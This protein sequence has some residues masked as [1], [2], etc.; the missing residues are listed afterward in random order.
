M[1]VRVGLAGHF[2]RGPE[3]TLMGAFCELATTGSRRWIRLRQSNDCAKGASQSQS[4]GGATEFGWLAALVALRAVSRWIAR[5]TDG[6][7]V[8][9]SGPLLPIW[10][11]IE[12][13]MPARWAVSGTIRRHLEVTGERVRSGCALLRGAFSRDRDGRCDS[14]LRSEFR[15][16]RSASEAMRS[17]RGGAGF[18]TTAS[19]RARALRSRHPESASTIREIGGALGAIEPG[20]NPL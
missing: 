20:V 16:R 4:L 3:E 5:T 9:R 7:R 19:C 10:R 2:H 1:R 13:D 8:R 12:V 6:I 17:G 15:T 11:A 18:G 14:S